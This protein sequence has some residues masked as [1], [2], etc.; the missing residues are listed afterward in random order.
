MR[1][2]AI[3]AGLV[4]IQFSS[5]AIAQQVSVTA[6][7]TNVSQ[8]FSERVGV[9]FNLNHPNFSLGF[10]GPGRGGFGGGGFSGPLD[11][12]SSGLSL[13]GGKVN[14]NF[15]LTA[16]QS[17]SRS[18]TTTA[19][20]ITVMNG[21]PGFIFS[22][23]LEPFVTRLNPVVGA[24]MPAN[25]PAPVSRVRNLLDTGEI[26]LK[27]DS[28]GNTRL[29]INE[30]PPRRTRI[31]PEPEAEPARANSDSS[32]TFRRALEKYGGSKR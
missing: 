7:S 32:N 14:A 31:E 25:Q 27:K 24:G 9:G 4:A 19:P 8:S 10:G 29:V 28:D 5:V 11:G 18:L 17:F 12:L 30:P 20:T 6:P 2:F 1:C 16:G 22:G 23:T 13:R 3:F 26:Q 15:S 21:V